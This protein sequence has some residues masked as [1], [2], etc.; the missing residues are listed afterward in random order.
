[1]NTIYMEL[2]KVG[3]GNVNS[4]EENKTFVPNQGYNNI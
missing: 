1:M 3:W 2:D 4:T